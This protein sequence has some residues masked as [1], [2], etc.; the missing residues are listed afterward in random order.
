MG[1]LKRMK[2]IATAD[3]HDTLDRMEDPISMLKHYLRELEAEMAK[4]QKGLAQ[5]L[6]IEKKFEAMIESTI[7]RVQ[8][9]SR[10]AELAVRYNEENIARIAI[11]DKL[12]QEAKLKTYQQQYDSIR[13]QTNLLYDQL[14]QLKA[15]YDE[16]QDR[17]LMLISRLTVAQVAN[18][19]SA[20]LASINPEH[21]VRGFRRVEEEVLKLEA[22]AQA[23][24]YMAQ[25]GRARL[26]ELPVSSS[27]EVEQELERLKDNNSVTI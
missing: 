22:K 17:K 23:N 14:D 15:K 19:V 5:Q 3:L 18:D 2:D 24:Q 4:A 1:I 9:R 13:S 21:A 6:Y 10:Q 26:L 27:V 20:V 25:T 11:E 16:L 8:R 7:E 12:S